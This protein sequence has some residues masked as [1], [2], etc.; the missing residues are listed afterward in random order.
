MVDI[1]SY[2]YKPFDLSLQFASFFTGNNGCNGGYMD[3][4]F[5]YVKKNGGISTE[6]S[7]PYVAKVRY[8]INTCGGLN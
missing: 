2:Y 6:A 5:A 1:M 4:S 7:Y 3:Y 8:I